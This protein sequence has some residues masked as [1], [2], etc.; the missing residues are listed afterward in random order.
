MSENRGE[1][2]SQTQP[3]ATLAGTADARNWLQERQRERDGRPAVSLA[4]SERKLLLFAGDVVLLNAAL[5]LGI[6]LAPRAGIPLALETV[7]SNPVWFIVLTA[8]WWLAA[9]VLDSYDLR[10]AAGKFTGPLAALK[11]LL[12]V[13]VIYFFIP[14]WSAPLTTTRLAWALI[15][16]FGAA[17]LATWRFL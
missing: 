14:Y 1:T 10:A 16:L 9:L 15:V 8:L 7:V 12:P 13:A 17:G 2:T 11:S 3:A 4:L 5:L 6:G